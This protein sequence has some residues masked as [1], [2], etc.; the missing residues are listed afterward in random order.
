[1]GGGTDGRF[2]PRAWQLPTQEFFTK[3]LGLPV[4]MNPDFNDLSCRMVFGQIPPP[5]EQDAVTAERCFSECPAASL[6][7]PVCPKI[8]TTSLAA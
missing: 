1:V 6:G 4:T 8:P 2:G 7:K 5:I 3:T